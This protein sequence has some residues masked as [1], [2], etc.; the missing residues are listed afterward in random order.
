MKRL[1]IAGYR[2]G[3]E[4]PAR[5]LLA[6]RLEEDVGIDFELKQMKLMRV[7]GVSRIQM[8]KH[9]R[10]GNS[11]KENK[12]QEKR[13]IVCQI[14]FVATNS[15]VLPLMDFH[16]IRRIAWIHHRRHSVYRLVK[17]IETRYKFVDPSA[18]R[19]MISF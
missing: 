10:G 19:P 17:G 18:P 9:P 3:T 1:T 15:S 16:S 7:L 14:E 6:W 5:I 4:Q 2:C 12:S 11:E 13:P 8:N